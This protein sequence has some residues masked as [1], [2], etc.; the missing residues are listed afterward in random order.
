MD[1]IQVPGLRVTPNIAHRGGI[2]CRQDESADALLLL[3]S[4]RV[5]IICNRDEVNPTD[6]QILHAGIRIEILN[7]PGTLIATSTLFMHEHLFSHLA[8]E[9]N[10]RYLELVPEEPWPRILEATP[11]L[12]IGLAHALANQVLSAAQ[13]LRQAILFEHTIHR[14]HEHFRR[15]AVTILEQAE[16]IL[17]KRIYCE[18]TERLRHLDQSLALL[19]ARLHAPHLHDVRGLT[20]TPARLD[21]ARMALLG[22]S[23]IELQAGE[24]LVDES[25]E[26]HALYLVLAGQLELL[27]AGEVL[28]RLHADDFVGEMGLLAPEV[29]TPFIRVRALTPCT[30]YRVCRSPE[31]FHSLMRERPAAAATMV[32]TIAGRLGT[33]DYAMALKC[34]RMREAIRMIGSPGCRASSAHILSELATLLQAYEFTR[35]LGQEARMAEE[36]ARAITETLESEFYEKIIAQTAAAPQTVV[37]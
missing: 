21:T 6:D 23:R 32:R 3:Q 1:D 4:G 25:V 18:M 33:F 14:T 10:T 8:L 31:E 37:A 9:D 22:P 35:S 13:H 2:L 26:G 5:S 27:V 7:Q 28:D 11:A 17:K 36:R 15:E 19:R 12:A 16:S 20:S 29:H 34:H 24:H 30:L